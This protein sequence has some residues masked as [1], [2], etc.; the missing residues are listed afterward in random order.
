MLLRLFK[1]H[2]RFNTFVID[3]EY[4]VNLAMPY[5]VAFGC[6]SRAKK[7]KD[8][9]HFIL[10]LKTMNP[11]VKNSGCIIANEKTSQSPL[12]TANCAQNIFREIV[13]N[14]TQRK[15]K[16]MVMKMPNLI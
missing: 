3:F 1:K 2:S 6:K 16:N 11:Y 13:L 12:S 8:D 9:Y 5:C 10:F 7:G 4:L 15:W 14:E